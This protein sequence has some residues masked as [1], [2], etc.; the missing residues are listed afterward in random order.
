MLKLSGFLLNLFAIALF[1]PGIVY[2]MFSI[3]TELVAQV[4][5]TSLASDLVSKELS[6]LATIEELWQDNRIAVAGLLF[7][8]S[9]CIPIFKTLLMSISYLK[10]GTKIERKLINFVASIGKWSMAD[11]FVV[12]IFLAFLS[13]NHTET[14]NNEQISM[15]GF[16]IELLISSETLSSVGAGFYY[17]TAYCLVS[18]IATQLSQLGL[19]KNA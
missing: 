14:A 4:G 18:L 17:F 7:L 19:T 10:R 12:A 15:F 13:T 2:P 11:V 3:N 6:L 5:Q 9:I 8:F 16:K 1:V